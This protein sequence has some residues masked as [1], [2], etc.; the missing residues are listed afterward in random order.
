MTEE[1]NLR[2][3]CLTLAV[4]G[5]HDGDPVQKAQDYFEFVANR[6]KKELRTGEVESTK[7]L[8]IPYHFWCGSQSVGR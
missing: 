8:T 1:E 5:Y 3:Q 6:D 7:S 2:Y 4:N